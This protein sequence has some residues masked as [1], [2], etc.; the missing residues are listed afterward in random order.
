MQADAALITLGQRV[1]QLPRQ[2]ARQSVRAA[3]PA[4]RRET[5]CVQRP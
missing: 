2:L 3:K 5:L 1:G 4:D